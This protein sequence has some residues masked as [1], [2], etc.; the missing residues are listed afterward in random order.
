[1]AGPLPEERVVRPAGLMRW[2][3]V[4]FL[5]WAYDPEVVAPLVPAGLTL[6][7]WRGQAWVGIVSFVMAAV[8]PPLLP[9]LPGLS[10]FPEI[11][12]RTY[13][14]APDGSDGLLFLT[15]E[16]SQPA[17]LAARASVGIRYA[18]A[19]MRIRADAEAVSYETRRRWPRQPAAVSRHTIEVGDAIPA[20][21]LTLFDHYLTGRWRAF[22][23]RWGQLFRTPVEHE[24][25]LLHRALVSDID[26]GLVASCGLPAPEGEPVAHYSPGV[27][28]RMGP[29]SRLS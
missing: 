5:H 29:P 20:A 19:S 1:M 16:A 18:W 9:A 26:D 14:R 25:W 21:E 15:L 12:V 27:N 28:V 7:L 2:D 13:V 22:S 17:A 3:A 8:R 23:S 10:T 4:S 6:D 24:P 11:N